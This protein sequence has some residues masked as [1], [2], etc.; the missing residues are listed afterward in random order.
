MISTYIVADFESDDKTVEV[1]YINEEDFEY[2]K[3]LD[4]GFEKSRAQMKPS[5]EDLEN[6]EYNEENFEY[7]RECEVLKPSE[8]EDID[9]DTLNDLEVIVFDE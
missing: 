2:T 9:Y 7:T 8:E 3:E 6:E 1:T 5:D 4:T